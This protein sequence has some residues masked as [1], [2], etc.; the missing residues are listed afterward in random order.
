MLWFGI[1]AEER[2][3][4]LTVALATVLVP[5][6]STMIAV[7]LPG[8]A[9]DFGSGL[10]SAGWPVTGYLVAM[11][12]L[13][14]LG[15]KLGDRFGRRRVILAGLSVFGVASL[16]AAAAPSLPLLMAFR[17]L[18]AVSGALVMPNG[19]A[20]VRTMLPAERRTRGVGLVGAAAGL[21]AALGPPLGGALVNAVEWRAI[22][23]VNVPIVA[24]AVFTGW[25]A[26]PRDAARAGWGGT[27]D[28]AGAVML[29]SFLISVA[30]LLVFSGRGLH[31][32]VLAAWGTATA[33][34]AAAFLAWELRQADP[35]FQPRF[36]RQRAFLAAN[37]AVCLSNMAM[38]SRLLVVPILLAARGGHSALHIGLILTS[39]S[40]GM[41]LLTPVGGRIADELGRRWPSVAGF[42]LLAGGAVWIAAGGG[43]VS[44]AA[45]IGG[46]ALAGIGLGVANPGVST[47]AVESL[48]RSQAGSASGVFSTSRYLGSI[49]GSAVL[50][51]LLGA[52][53]DRL[54]QV[55]T[56]FVIIAVAAAG[57]V[58][59]AMALRSRPPGEAWP[60]DSASGGDSNR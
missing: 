27:F 49:V 12:S 25:R 57:S 15:G 20:L 47:S 36:F 28:S 58:L 32:G 1:A 46:L 5:L 30:A 23:L 16:A 48:D 18:Q 45:L 17:I 54:V 34:G 52:G 59:A 9:R 3:V 33:L 13:Q 53:R 7:A 26:L 56:V 22:F 10:S 35:V 39:L 19:A 6:N 55:E 44:V 2:P 37:L 8:I 40:A 60:R 42:V 43:D 14:P 31:P 38:Y 11:A 24:A 4:M 51:G 29:P 41:A 50:A 21:A